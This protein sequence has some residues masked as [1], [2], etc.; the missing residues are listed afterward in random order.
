MRA[1]PYDHPGVP[2][3]RSPLHFLGWIGRGQWRTLSVAIFFGVVWM[4][5]QALFP[6]AMSR[7]IDEGI[8][9]RDSAA[10]IR[11]SLV[12]LGL[13]II[14]AGAGVMR[15]RMAVTN[16]LRATFR[17]V[18]LI[19]WHSAETGEALPRHSPTGDVVAVVASDAMRI[20]GLYDVLARFVGAIVSFGVVAVILLQASLP[21]GLVVLIGVPVLLGLL[22][23]LV[24]PLQLR[25]AEQ[26]EE[27]GRLIGLGADT[28][29]GL[30]VLRGIGGETTYLARYAR[31]SQEV[32][33]SGYR[34][35]GVQSALDAAQVL[36]PGLFVLVVTWL[37]ARFA[38]QGQISV[39]Q[40]VAFYGY[41]AFLVMPLRTAT[42]FLDRFTRARIGA[43]KA[44]AVLR[45]QPDHADHPDI[46][47]AG[48]PA[49]G[50]AL[51]DERTGITLASG[52][53]TVVVSARPEDTAALA[54]RLGR[55]GTAADGVRLG[56]S[57]LT[58]LP[59]ATVRRR[60][61][62]S[63]TDPRLFSG[64]LR[65]ELDPWGR[66]D[67]DEI[68]AALAV[69][70]GEDVLE[71]LPA[72]LDSEVEERG[73]SFSGGQRQ[74]LALTRALLTEADTL[75]LV[76]PTSAVDAH[77]EARVAGRLAAARAGRTTVVMSASPLVLDHA[78]HVAFLRDGRLAASGTHR[79]LMRDHPAYRAVVVRGE[80]D[81]SD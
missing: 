40:L 50:A 79:E 3:L 36:L 58:D 71:A 62:V 76:E 45:V 54:D 41:S 68:L 1:L 8:V 18:Q 28:V 2:D 21:L 65:S 69:A 73:R 14:S 64:S 59:V 72:G 35:A 48:E 60:V 30:R 66:H 15:H 10:L 61:V 70:S 33:A 81:E 80:E 5:G 22:T 4:V 20:G 77:T 43:G 19:G 11:W 37:G 23:F 13:G 24:R 56:G 52:R 17:S 67:D 7:A 53:L 44:I 9:G 38:L 78:D 16:W 49:A 12:L 25:Q 26:R 34:V 46:E 51:V 31:Q 57:L 39:G 75:V 74:R 47:P 55:F 32:R 63:E 6:A 29:A 27:S 42:E